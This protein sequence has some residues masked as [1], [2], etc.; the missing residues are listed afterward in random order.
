LGRGK[1]KKEGTLTKANEVV[2]GVK[3]ELGSQGLTE[4]DST[5][6]VAELVQ[7]RREH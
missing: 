2:K 6:S 7:S 3:L 5:H 4:L 1:E